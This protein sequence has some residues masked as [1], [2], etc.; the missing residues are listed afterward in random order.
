MSTDSNMNY[1]T[2]INPYDLEESSIPH[3]NTP[4]SDIPFDEYIEFRNSDYISSGTMELSDDSNEW[5]NI[6]KETGIFGKDWEDTYK[7]AHKND[8]AEKPDILHEQLQLD[9]SN[10]TN[11]YTAL[12]GYLSKKPNCQNLIY[13][14]NFCHIK[15]NIVHDE[16]IK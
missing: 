1:L 5:N 9:K 8:I 16:E 2:I 14:Q 15:N 13:N 11:S 4:V 7:L 12:D 3:T 6:L 10:E